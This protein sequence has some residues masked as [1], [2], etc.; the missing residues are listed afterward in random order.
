M[1]LSSIQPLS[2]RWLHASVV[3]LHWIL[4]CTMY[5]TYMHIHT[6]T[7]VCEI[8]AC[9]IFGATLSA[10]GTNTTRVFAPYEIHSWRKKR[11]K[12]ELSVAHAC[13]YLTH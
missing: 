9:A 13:T 12:L 11:E 3:I 4:H 6:C 2:L 1:A 5:S 10:T 8:E 7:C